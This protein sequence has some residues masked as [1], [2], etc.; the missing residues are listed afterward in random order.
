MAA[1]RGVDAMM[2]STA[3]GV[4][5]LLWL[6]LAVPIWI[7]PLTSTFTASKAVLWCA[8]VAA[9]VVIF[10][11]PLLATMVYIRVIPE[12]RNPWQRA[13]TQP[14]VILGSLL[15][16]LPAKIAVIIG[17]NLLAGVLP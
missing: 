8:S 13:V 4:V 14:I 7:L 1:A 2:M 15:S 10:G 5:V 16:I 17:V 9:D 11:L 6:F 3:T 12:L